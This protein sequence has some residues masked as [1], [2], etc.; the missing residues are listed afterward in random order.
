MFRLQGNFHTEEHML[1]FLNK[2]NYLHLVIVSM[3][4]NDRSTFISSLIHLMA[5]MNFL[6]GKKKCFHDI[7]SFT[8]LYRNS[9]FAFVVNMKFITFRHIIN[10]YIITEYIIYSFIMFTHSFISASHLGITVKNSINSV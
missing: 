2:Q 7:Y 4:E 1:Q 10:K 6:T 5:T 3:F 8:V 9:Y